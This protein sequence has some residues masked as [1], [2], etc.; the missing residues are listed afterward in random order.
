ML[1]D[2]GGALGTGP[3]A[4]SGACSARPAALVPDNATLCSP[5]VGVWSAPLATLFWF[6]CPTKLFEDDAGA[7]SAALSTPTPASRLAPL[8]GSVLRH[9]RTPAPNSIA[10]P[11]PTTIP[12]TDTARRRRRSRS[13]E[14]PR[15]SS[16]SHFSCGSSRLV[17][18]S[19]KKSCSR[20]S[21]SG[22]GSARGSCPPA[23]GA[24]GS[25][26]M[27][28]V[29]V[30]GVVSCAA[31]L[32]LSA[33]S[34]TRGTGVGRGM[35]TMSTGTAGGFSVSDNP[36]LNTLRDS[37]DSLSPLDPPI[38]STLATAT[39]PPGA[40]ENAPTRPSDDSPSSLPR[41]TGADGRK[42]GRAAAGLGSRAS[43]THGGGG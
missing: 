8:T 6:R 37:R 21:D 9:A 28:G 39:A 12:S 4:D 22:F 7:P 38:G 34:S 15:C 31:G 23:L 16:S 25:I 36:G 1:A 14:S 10:T 24:G 2:T 33:S 19:R 43:A 11:S 42:E 32:A 26:T 29:G 18:S 30:S 3:V 17:P 27:A 20:K 35:V 5:E 40:V 41:A 13:R